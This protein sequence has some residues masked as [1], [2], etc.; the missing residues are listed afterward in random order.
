MVEDEEDA[1][2]KRQ[3]SWPF[4]IFIL[5]EFPNEQCILDSIRDGP[6]LQVYLLATMAIY[7]G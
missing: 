3:I 7:Y 5:N 1:P 4:V 2:F 6:N